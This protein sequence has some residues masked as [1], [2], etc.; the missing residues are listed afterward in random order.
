MGSHHLPPYSILCT[1]LRGPHLNGFL[2]RDSQMGVSKFPRLEL[3]RL[4][5]AIT[6]CANLGS[7]WGLKQ[8]CSLC[9]EFSN[10]VSP[11]TCTQGIRVDSQLFVV[12]SQIRS[13]IFGSLFLFFMAFLLAIT[14]VLDVQMGHASLFQTS[15][16]Q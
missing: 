9:W 6:S 8:S 16:F 3:P 15:K 1:S 14:C 7:G 5:D 10:G 4:C 2:S 12:G 13:L 11:T